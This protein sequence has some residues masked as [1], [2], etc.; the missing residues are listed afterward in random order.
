MGNLGHGVRT[1][2]PSPTATAGIF[3]TYPQEFMT[4]GTQFVSEFVASSI[5]MFVIFGLKDDR[6]GLSKVRSRWVRILLQS[7]RELK[8]YRVL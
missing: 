5:L 1:V 3:C 2:P 8:N 6:N 4:N 7:A